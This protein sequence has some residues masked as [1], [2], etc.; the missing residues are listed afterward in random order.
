MHLID[1]KKIF[2]KILFDVTVT[3]YGVDETENY[4]FIWRYIQLNKIICIQSDGSDLSLKT[5]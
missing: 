1:Q 2:Y 5:L 3:L 4:I